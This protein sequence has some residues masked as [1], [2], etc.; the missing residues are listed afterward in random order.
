[1]SGRA[2]VTVLFAMV[3]VPHV[4]ALSR[5]WLGPNLITSKGPGRSSGTGLTAIGTKI[6]LFGGDWHAR[7]NE[8]WVFDAALPGNGWTDLTNA[9]AAVGS[10]PSERIGPCMLS[11]GSDIV[12]FGGGIGNSGAFNDL[13]TLDTNDLKAGWQEHQV[14]SSAPVERETPG[15]AVVGS[16]L[17]VY[18]GLANIQQ[19][20]GSGEWIID[21]WRIDLDNT[22]NGWTELAATVGSGPT[23]TRGPPFTAI[24]TKLYT[25]SAGNLWVLETTNLNAGWTCQARTC[26]GTRSWAGE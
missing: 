4:Q 3:L 11:R 20:F 1:M 6:Y 17:Y 16:H 13:W 25:M 5:E 15:C 23:Q 26:L 14:S 7:G 24:G 18:G 9:L 12:L 2:L 8:M 19:S 10:S 22:A 21:L